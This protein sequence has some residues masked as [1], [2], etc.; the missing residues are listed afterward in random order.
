MSLKSTLLAFSLPL[1]VAGCS[2]SSSSSSDPEQQNTISVSGLKYV[3]EDGSEGFTDSS[4]LIPASDQTVQFFLGNI[5]LGAAVNAT[6]DALYHF[7]ASSFPQDQQ[8]LNVAMY[9][10]DYRG[11]SQG[12]DEYNGDYYN[13]PQSSHELMA[14]Q[15]TRISNIAQLLASFD[16]DKNLD[17]GIQLHE[18]I[19]EIIDQPDLSFD[20]SSDSKPEYKKVYAWLNTAFDLGYV[21]NKGLYAPAMALSWAFSQV[22]TELQVSV[23]NK[24]MR[25]GA[26]TS[27]SEIEG[28]TF[29]ETGLLAST[30]YDLTGS[31][32]SNSEK[33]ESH[34]AF[35]SQIKE[36]DNEREDGIEAWTLTDSREKTL[37]QHNQKT[38]EQYTAIAGS[39]YSY[40]YSIND[41]GQATHYQTFED[42]V[43]QFQTKTTYQNNGVDRKTYLSTY[44]NGSSQLTLRVFDESDNITIEISDN[45]N[46]GTSENYKV[47]SYN[48]FGKVLSYKEYGPVE[49]SYDATTLLPTVLTATPVLYTQATYTY[50]QDGDNLGYSSQSTDQCPDTH[51]CENII[52]TYDYTDGKLVSESE[53]DLDGRSY[54]SNTSIEYHESTDII[55]K[56]ITVY[57]GISGYTNTTEYNLNQQITYNERDSVDDSNSHFREINTYTSEG[58]LEL[59]QHWGSL[60]DIQNNTFSSRKHSYNENGQMTNYTSDWDA[61]GINNQEYVMTYKNGLLVEWVDYDVDAATEEKTIDRRETYEFTQGNFNYASY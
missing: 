6:P 61:D 60:L 49:Y 57:T 2:S 27:P 9:D 15:L 37:N 31:G 19:H 38:Y 12:I 3:Q 21:E 33:I 5:P 29:T 16:S 17:N 28:R 56:R 43:L 55:S 58:L 54:D 32:Q 22:D 26:D 30:Y 20:T 59:Y 39:D 10:L 46:D 35:G 53:T 13:E 34:N 4:G 36:I 51:Y 24:T 52:Q 42:T 7:V 25:Y 11:R 18:S 41:A 14:N 1:F 8:A 40:S 47:F 23:L 44:H 48:E 45:E 50:N